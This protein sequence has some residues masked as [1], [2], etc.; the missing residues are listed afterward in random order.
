M[1]V[2]GRGRI[3][4]SQRRK[5]LGF[6][7]KNCLAQSLILTTSHLIKVFMGVLTSENN[8]IIINSCLHV[9]YFTQ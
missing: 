1:P 6:N 2:E 7:L 3:R 5:N 8:A 9:V 4:V